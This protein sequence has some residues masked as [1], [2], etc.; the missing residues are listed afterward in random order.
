MKLGTHKKVTWGDHDGKIARTDIYFDAEDIDAL[1]PVGGRA[2]RHTDF[3]EMEVTTKV[4]AWRSTEVERRDSGE[5][6]LLVGR[7]HSVDERREAMDQGK[8]AFLRLLAE[9]ADGTW[10][11]QTAARAASLQG[12]ED[13]VTAQLASQSKALEASRIFWTERQAADKAYLGRLDS[14]HS[15]SS[16]TFMPGDQAREERAWRTSMEQTAEESD[17]WAQRL[18]GLITRHESVAGQIRQSITRAVGDSDEASKAVR[19][20]KSDVWPVTAAPGAQLPGT[21]A[22]DMGPEGA[23]IWRAVKRYLAACDWLQSSQEV[24]LARVQREEERSVRLGEWVDKVLNNGRKSPTVS[25][26]LSDEVP[27]DTPKECGAR[28]GPPFLR[29]L[30]DKS[31]S[32]SDSE[33]SST[34]GLGAS[35]DLSALV[36]HEQ[37]VEMRHSEEDGV[38]WQSARMLLSVDLWLHVWT[39]EVPANGDATAS[40]PLPSACWRPVAE[41]SSEDSRV[42]RFHFRTPSTPSLLEG[43]ARRLRR[44]A[45]PPP[46]SLCLRCETSNMAKELL[47]VFELVEKLY[48]IIL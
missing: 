30:G 3:P 27:G 11:A 18:P 38:P 15:S 10:R 32:D 35:L 7:R 5:A 9:R 13:R 26:A 16:M 28:P 31:E 34:E 39:S 12:I 4:G 29:R 43:L 41:V 6:W 23:C 20:A 33:D 47:Q 19:T 42:L 2:R 14:C 17:S 1:T 8:T 46:R 24:A 37:S 36:V 22:S 48:P 25:P 21:H 44:E 45:D 40:Y